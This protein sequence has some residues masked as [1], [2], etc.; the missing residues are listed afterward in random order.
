MLLLAGLAACGGEPEQQRRGGRPG[1]GAVQVITAVVTLQQQET[2]IEAVGTARARASITIFPETGGTVTEVLFAPG[3]F[4][5]AN[6]PLLRLE[7]EE[8]AL[9]VR[10]AEVAVREAE[11]LLARY[12]RIEGTGAVS[13]SQVDEAQTALDAA[14]IRVDQ[15]KL[16]LARRTVV[17]P[18]AGHV[19]LTDVDPGARITATTAIT[20]LDDRSRLFVDFQVPEQLFGRIG[21]GDRVD[22][23]PFAGNGT[24]LSAQISAIDSRVDEQRRSFAVRATLDNS[25]DQLRPGMSFRVALALAGDMFPAVPE[26]AILWGSDGSYVWAVRDG[27]AIQIPVTI[28][29]RKDG[30]VL[31]RGPLEEGSLV[32]AEGVQRVREGSQVRV[33]GEKGRS[34]PSASEA[35]EPEAG[36]AGR[37]QPGT[38]RQPGPENQES[39][40]QESG[41][42]GSGDRGSSASGSG[43]DSSG[44]NSTDNGER[45]L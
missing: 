4:L 1:G 16:T 40:N 20:R 15:A 24:T 7:N 22:A 36:Q 2:R 30:L 21:P 12:R 45:A 29:A 35:S 25:A 26:A 44:S 5:E 23:R 42:Q 17:A 19:G 8:E 27:Q 3:D 41:D 6:A 10:L 13:D 33:N 11:Q 39:E 28:A 38:N 37:S 9:A 43:T 31:V 14:R 34:A 18:F 32:V